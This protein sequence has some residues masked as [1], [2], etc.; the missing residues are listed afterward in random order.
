LF[1]KLSEEDL[2]EVEQLQNMVKEDY[3]V[4]D[5]SILNMQEDIVADDSDIDS[6]EEEEDGE[7]PVLVTAFN[8]S[9]GKRAQAVFKE[10]NEDDDPNVVKYDIEEPEDGDNIVPEVIKTSGSKTVHESNEHEQALVEKEEPEVILPPTIH[11]KEDTTV[12]KQD[13]LK[14]EESNPSPPSNRFQLKGKKDKSQPTVD[15]TLADSETKTTEVSEEQAAK[16]G[17][18]SKQ[19]LCEEAPVAQSDASKPEQEEDHQNQVDYGD[20]GQEEAS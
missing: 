16:A 14:V 2:Q 8:S 3:V 1:K 19:T 10:D 12:K 20:E 5:E 9:P 7:E 17:E 4:H 13:S 6:S 15:Q 18:E 11:P